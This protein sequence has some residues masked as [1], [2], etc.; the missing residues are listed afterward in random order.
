MT[1]PMTPPKRAVWNVDPRAFIERLR[2]G[3]ASERGDGSVSADAL[4]QAVLQATRDLDPTPDQWRSLRD[5]VRRANGLDAAE[6]EGSPAAMWFPDDDARTSSRLALWMRETGHRDF[7]G[8]RQWSLQHRDEF[9]QSAVE[10]LGIRFDQPPGQILDL[11]RGVPA[12]AWFPGARLNIVADCF[13]ADA[14]SPAIL[15]RRP[16]EEMKR[17]E[18]AELKRNVAGIVGAIRKSGFQPGDAL[19][20][21]LP[22]TPLSV[23]LYLAII[24]AGCR[25]V[26]IADSFAPPEIGNRLRIAGARAVFTYDVQVR[27]GRTLP[28]YRKVCDAT[29]LPTIVL[30]DSENGLQLPLRGQDRSWDG[31]LENCPPDLAW[32]SAGSGAIINVLFS[33]GTTGDPKAIPWTQLTPV[34]CAVDGMLHQD[35]RPGQVVCWPTSLGWMMGPWLV[36][37]ALLNRATIALYED[38]P[39]GPDFGRFVEE[40]GVHMLGVVPTLV[41]A[42]RESRAMEEFD[43]S[44]IHV[45][46]ST[47]ESSRADDMFYLSSLAN[48][49]PVIEYCGGTEIGGGYI[50]QTVLEPNLPAAFSTPAA[51]LDFVIL[52]SDDLPAAEGELFLIPPA[53]GLS[54][55]L[56]NRDHTE[57]YFD[58]TPACP[59]T[60]AAS[61]GTVPAGTCLRRHGDHFRRLPGGYYVAGGRVDDTMNLGGIKTSS[62]EIERVL[63]LLPGIRETAA[64]AWAAGSGPDELHVFYVPDGNGLPADPVAAMNERIKAELNPLFKVRAVHEVP[65]LPRTASNKVMRRL[66]RDQLR[67]S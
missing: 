43:W 1:G 34:K 4:W 58:G 65:L 36:F 3:L 61:G 51:G 20:V 2:A 37:A 13:Q 21:V 35:I 47:G 18:V 8:F 23:A 12:A 66:L 63:N 62:A 26:S 32:Q 52:D 25:A 15:S 45:F 64:I 44:Q 57:T 38:V 7:A 30:A 5:G 22:M 9:W 16:G 41:R 48:I 28:L 55:T 27:G 31:F 11:S 60:I 33:S 42:W 46:S 29:D 39:M 54:S 19:G 67:Q 24:A 6:G 10:R 40:A 59:A 14:T 49:R 17:M 56:I 53:V 50:S